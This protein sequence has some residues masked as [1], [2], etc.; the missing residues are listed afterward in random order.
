MA[1]PDD[2]QKITVLIQGY[3]F[4]V[5]AP[6]LPG[7]PIGV[8]EAGV[9]NREW[10]QAVRASFLPTMT[11]A[12]EELGKLTPITMANLQEEF[13]RHAEA[14]AFKA[15]SQTRN[16]DPLLRQIH[17]IAKKVLDIRLNA[18]GSSRAL[19]GEQRYEAAL[20]RIMNNPGVVEQAKAQM[21]AT[22]DVA[23][24]LAGME[25]SNVSP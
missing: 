10:T 12:L 8:A 14:F 25:N 21:A 4:S 18:Q 11:A 6:Y 15:L 19:F 22:R 1:L 5:P 2:P 13:Q 23:N 16:S 24:Q 17:S 9:L 20:A 7:M 3:Q